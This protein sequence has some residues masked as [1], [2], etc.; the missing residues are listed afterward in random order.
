MARRLLIAGN[1]KL[2][3]TVEE[4]VSLAGEIATGLFPRR[5]GRAG[6]P[7]LPGPGAGGAEPVFQLGAGGAGK[8]YFGRSKE[9]LPARVGPSQ[10][11]AAGARYVLVGH[12]ERRQ[13]FGETEKTC[14][15][16]LAASLVAGL[17]PILCV[18][19]TQDEREKDQT[20]GV[21]ESQ[22]ARRPGRVQR[23][24]GGQDNH[25]L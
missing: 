24:A 8:T 25:R 18:G 12:S 16:R 22:L 3:K 20:E 6:H 17:L 15:L 13:Y 10:L 11:K 23:G 9:P 2:H 7:R 4:A 21:L 14:N 5:P 19:E 1:W